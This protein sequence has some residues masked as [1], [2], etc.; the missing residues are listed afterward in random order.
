M[1]YKENTELLDD[2]DNKWSVVI[3]YWKQRHGRVDIVKEDVT[4]SRPLMLNP[5]EIRKIWAEVEKV[6][7]YWNTCV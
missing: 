6:C 2:I 5:K 3:N 1:P 7:I 4:K